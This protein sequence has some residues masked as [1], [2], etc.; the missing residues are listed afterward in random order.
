MIDIKIAKKV[1]VYHILLLT[2]FIS[3]WNQTF[4]LIEYIIKLLL[5]AV[6]FL[7]IF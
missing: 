7:L 3:K 1:D 2:K 6:T 4:I 5:G